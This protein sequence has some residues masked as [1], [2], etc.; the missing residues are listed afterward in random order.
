L[1]PEDRELLLV[2]NHLPELLEKISA[3]HPRT[4]QMPAKL[5]AG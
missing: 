5:A 1:K 4:R 3:F 2:D